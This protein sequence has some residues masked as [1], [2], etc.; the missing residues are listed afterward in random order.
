MGQFSDGCAPVFTEGKPDKTGLVDCNG[1][2]LVRDFKFENFSEGLGA[3]KDTKT[4]LY[5]YADRMGIVR[6]QPQFQ[7]ALSFCEGL[8]VVGIKRKNYFPRWQLNERKILSQTGRIPSAGAQEFD[9]S[10]GAAYVTRQGKLLDVQL[11]EPKADI[12]IAHPFNHG[13]G[14]IN[15][16]SERDVTYD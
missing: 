13:I 12:K 14:Y 2:F 10:V 9:G 16:Y 15:L 3:F 1:N 6:I 4:G 11:S 5:G 8:A 7:Y